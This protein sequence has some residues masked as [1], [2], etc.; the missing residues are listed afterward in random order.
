MESLRSVN[1][2]PEQRKLALNTKPMNRV[3][4]G[5]A[6]SGKTTSA[7]FLLK[8]GLLHYKTMKRRTGDITPI[9]AVVITFNKTLK[10]YVE[11]LAREIAD[12][13]DVEVVHLAKYM[14]DH[15]PYF[16]RYSLRITPQKMNIPKDIFYKSP[17]S[18]E[19]T[20][21]EIEYVLGRYHHGEFDQYVEI[22]TANRTDEYSTSREIRREIVEYAIKPYIEYKEANNFVDLNDL[23]QYFIENK[24]DAFEVL[25][26]DE[27]QDFSANDLRAIINQLSDDSFGTF[28]IDTAQKIYKRTFTWKEVGLNIRPE[29]SFRLITNYR[30]T[31][32]IAHFATSLLASVKLDQDSTLPDNSDCESGGR[33]PIIFEGKFGQQLDFTI[34]YIRDN[35][36]LQHET[37][38]F[39]H[40]KGYGYFK[41]LREILRNENLPF[42]EVT[43]QS[44]WP[45]GT[46][47]IALSTLHSVKGLEFDHVFMLGLEGDH[48][49]YLTHGDDSY[50]E[51]CRLVAMGI[52]RAKKSVVLGYKLDTKPLFIDDFES[53]T[54]QFEEA[55]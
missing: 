32:E 13:V 31:K 22:E 1:L 8:V 51:A 49:S 44:S 11:S 6:G 4:R 53:D 48:F 19:H 23:A 41:Y 50:Q 25:I 47:N 9:R 14:K 37:V 7:L 54:Y 38:A 24:I 29:N 30:N 26:A 55:R 33:Q 40:R 43:S 36:D 2:T 34:R 46:Q 3:I 35:I 15:Y 18:Y 27:C 28:V 52:T 12:D 39:L 21:A 42:C 17:I 16:D 5:A 20:L 10:A 45:E